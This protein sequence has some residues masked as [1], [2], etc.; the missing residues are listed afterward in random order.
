M[1]KRVP[2]KQRHKGGARRSAVEVLLGIPEG[3]RV[4]TP[5]PGES[6]NQASNPLEGFAVEVDG[7]V[8]FES[9]AQLRRKM[10]SPSDS[11]EREFVALWRRGLRLRAR[12]SRVR[13]RPTGVWTSE[14]VGL[15]MLRAIEAGVVRERLVWKFG[16][17]GAE[18]ARRIESRLRSNKG[19]PAANKAREAGLT[20]GLKHKLKVMCEYEPKISRRAVARRL[21][22]ESK[23]DN[24]RCH[25]C[26][27]S[28]WLSHSGD[29]PRHGPCEYRQLHGKCQECKDC[30]LWYSYVCEWRNSAKKIGQ[31][32]R[33]LTDKEIKERMCE[34]L[35]KRIGTIDPR[36]SRRWSGRKLGGSVRG[37]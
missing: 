1:S 22:E 9:L 36:P 23:G 31:D 35:A 11:L 26:Q 2:R 28:K 6:L 7:V 5:K 8:M 37:E 25:H 13:K 20:A 15:L 29:V 34:A 30:T 3:F 33:E 16:G 21:V 18:M 24:L 27:R 32:G 10:G 17:L 4:E 12:L 19:L 14:E